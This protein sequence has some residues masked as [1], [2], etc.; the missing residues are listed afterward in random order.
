[1]STTA[2]RVLG[3]LILLGTGIFSLPAVA[4]FLDGPSTQNWIIPVQLLIMALIGALVILALPAMAPAAASTGIRVL[5]G[6][7]WGV[8]AALVGLLVFFFLLNG[9]SGA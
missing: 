6:V 1:M 8:L 4:V 9:F 3:V 2:Q 5:I 7:G